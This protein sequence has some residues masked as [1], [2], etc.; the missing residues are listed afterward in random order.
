MKKTRMLLLVLLLAAAA[1]AQPPAGHPWHS[2]RVA[3]LG[4]S[5]T[6]ARH[7]AAS[8]KYWSLLQEWLGITPY[9]YGISGRQW[10][11]IPRQTDQLLADHGDE[12]DA[13]LVFAGT[14]DFNHG[15]PL[16]T[17]YEEC[18]TTVVAA[19]REP[20]HP[21]QR[22]MRRP[23]LDPDTYRGRINIALKKLKQCYPTRQ[24]V[25]LTPLHRS[26]AEFG[27]QNVQP[28]EAYQNACGEYLDR[29]VAA[30][31]EAGE[32]W[33]VPVIDWGM[34]SG[35]YPL[36]PEYAGYFYDPQN[37]LLHPNDEGHRRLAL[38]LFYQLQQLPCRF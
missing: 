19:V 27:E 5:I 26:Y 36:L 34:L 6:D 30:I 25:L 1:Q 8:Q 38:T 9:V 4:D 3:C 14:N 12:V 15:V 16:G 33:A 37:D 23:A 17:W 10:N 2:A 20:R 29:Y 28:S 35:L 21:V 18:D 11:D 31:R 13:I 32:V 24:I 7:R 22:K